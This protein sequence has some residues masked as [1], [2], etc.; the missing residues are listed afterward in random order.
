V[1]DLVIAVSELAANTLAHT[2]GPGSLAL[3]ATDSEVICQVNDTGQL[4]NPLAGRLRP[5]PAAAGGGRGYG[6]YSSLVT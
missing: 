3:W 5:D 4:A 1:G 6:L 2:S